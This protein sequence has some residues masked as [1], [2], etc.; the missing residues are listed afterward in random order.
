[1]KGSEDPRELA[2]AEAA[3]KAADR[4]LDRDFQ[5]VFG[6]ERG[7]RAMQAI[8]ATSQ[9]MAHIEVGNAMEMSYRLGARAIGL[10]VLERAKATH[11][12]LPARMESEFAAVAELAMGE[13][14]GANAVQ[15]D[16]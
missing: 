4:R 6:D 8:V 14:E 12:H 7:R 5:W 13:L 3:Q 16:D 2:R 9:A 15:T 11:P 1:M 10:F